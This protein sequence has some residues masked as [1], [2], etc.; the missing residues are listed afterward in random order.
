MS[1]VLHTYLLGHANTCCLYA[2]LALSSIN[3]LPNTII[4]TLVVIGRK[5]YQ[6]KWLQHVQ[7]MDTNRIPKQAIQYKPKDEGT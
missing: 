5:L 1:N 3:A 2:K 4:P 6:E 7:R